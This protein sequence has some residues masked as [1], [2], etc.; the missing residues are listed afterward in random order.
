M[1]RLL[2][3]IYPTFSEFEV[4]V[5]TTILAKAYEI[6]T[7][8]LD[9]SPVSGEGGLTCL[10]HVAVPEV[11]PADYAGMIIPGAPELRPVVESE[12]LLQLIR[13][14][15]A[16]AKPLAAICGGPAVLGK[17]GALT[18]RRYTAS[19]LPAQRKFLGMPE[20]GFTGEDL[21]QEDHVLTAIGQAYVEFGLTTARL[22]GYFRD[23]EY[24][25]RT[26]AFY[27][28]QERPSQKRT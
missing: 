21:V 2:L 12:P 13:A 22:F 20:E 17:A 6:V 24:F 9:R 16:A 18:G 28:N 1:P 7:I 4:T 8:G 11:N 27:R 5:A 3:L 10:P 19:L 14:F 15:D 23:E 26:A 25:E